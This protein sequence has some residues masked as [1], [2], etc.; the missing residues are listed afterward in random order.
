MS[1]ACGFWIPDRCVAPICAD[2][3][4][5][6][7]LILRSRAHSSHTF[8]GRS[9][10]NRQKKTP[11]SFKQCNGAEASVLPQCNLRI[12]PTTICLFTLT[13]QEHVPACTVDRVLCLAKSST[14]SCPLLLLRLFPC[15]S[16]KRRPEK[17]PTLTPSP[18]RSCVLFLT[19][20]FRLSST[21]VSRALFL[22]L[23]FQSRPV[24]SPISLMPTFFAASQLV[25]HGLQILL[26]LFII[27]SLTQRAP[28]WIDQRAR[29]I[30]IDPSCVKRRPPD[31]VSLPILKVSAS[32][33]SLTVAYLKFH[34]VEL[35]VHQLLH[36]D[37]NELP[38]LR[39]HIHPTALL[40]A[41]IHD[42]DE[43][44]P[45]ASSLGSPRG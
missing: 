42:L 9:R 25:V 40:D 17:L 23:S 5:V 20:P 1:R 8:K 22:S 13:T 39:H 3:D 16:W 36:Y 41:L 18:S 7:Q 38:Q 35:P 27:Q 31:T 45:P 29:P 24:R 6:P 26:L 28:V 4:T 44:L 11:L 32:G 21:Y 33:P 2:T 30:P 10:Q 19:W 37:L 14:S 34:Q 12:A 43:F 15:K